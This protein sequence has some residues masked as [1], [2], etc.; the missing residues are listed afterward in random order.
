MLQPKLLRLPGSLT[1]EFIQ[2]A[3]DL[4][5]GRYESDPHEATQQSGA[6]TAI[7]ARRSW[8]HFPSNSARPVSDR[9]LGQVSIPTLRVGAMRHC[10]TN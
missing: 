9:E 1:Q 2:L 8:T 10:R 3:S 5:A 6:I 7:S 4:R